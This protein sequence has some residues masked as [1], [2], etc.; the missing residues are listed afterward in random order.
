MNETP[1]QQFWKE[2]G[3]T[4][5]QINCHL[6]WER[7]KSKEARERRKRNN[8]KNKELIKQIKSDLLKKTFGNDTILYIRPTNDGIGFWYKTHKK[9]SDGSE[10]EFR[11][12]CHFED[13]KKEKFIEDLKI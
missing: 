8:E 2:K 10:G 5:E 7:Q 11:Y 9:F 1:R 3:Y 12:F 4:Q 6:E 13:Y